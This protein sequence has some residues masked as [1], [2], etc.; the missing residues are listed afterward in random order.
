[1]GH[2]PGH[3]PLLRRIFRIL[4]ERAAG[5]LLGLP[6]RAAENIGRLRERSGKHMSGLSDR[7]ARPEGLPEGSL[8]RREPAP[9]AGE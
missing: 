8:R 7:A 2:P 3:A 9:E 1:M 5:I 4:P 6:K